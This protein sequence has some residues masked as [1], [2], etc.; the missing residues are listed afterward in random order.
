MD[1]HTGQEAIITGINRG[2]E[3]RNRLLAM[4]ITPGSRITMLARHPFRGPLMIAIGNTHIALGRNLASAIE[5][6]TAKKQ[7]QRIVNKKNGH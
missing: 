3:A 6:T 1:L 4:G 7:S 5:I 2:E